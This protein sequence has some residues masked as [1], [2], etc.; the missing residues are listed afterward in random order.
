MSDPQST[1]ANESALSAEVNAPAEVTLFHDA[2]KVIHVLASDVEFWLSQGFRQQPIDIT[3]RAQTLKALFPAALD[4]VIA[5]AEVAQQH[6]HIDP[7]SE[8]AQATAAYAMRQLEAAY[9]ALIRD[10]EAAYPVL[11]GSAVPMSQN[12]QTI[13]VD[14]AQVDHYAA[15]GWARDEEQHDAAPAQ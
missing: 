8:A 10:I 15:Q 4:A 1:I 6:G 7:A 2:G 14:P 9:G 3:G 11:Q 13:L 5:F 12:G